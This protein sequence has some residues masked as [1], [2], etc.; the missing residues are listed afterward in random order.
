MNETRIK[1]SFSY[2]L[3]TFSRGPRVSFMENLVMVKCVRNCNFHGA[4]SWSPLW[5]RNC[6]KLSV[7]SKRKRRLKNT[8]RE[9]EKERNQIGL[10]LG[11]YERGSTWRFFTIFFPYSQ[12]ASWAHHLKKN[13]KAELIFRDGAS[14]VDSV[15]FLVGFPSIRC[16]RSRTIRHEEGWWQLGARSIGRE[17]KNWIWKL[18][19]NVIRKSMTNDRI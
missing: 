19:E 13:T 2:V 1:N 6:W 15:C 16:G 3:V 9:R 11:H 4:E 14:S 7:N 8:E 17:K 12:P 5:R 18:I 10:Q